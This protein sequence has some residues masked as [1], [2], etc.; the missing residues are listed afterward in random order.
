MF[1][2]FRRYAFLST[3]LGLIL[4]QAAVLY[5]L[6][7]VQG[8]ATAAVSATGSGESSPFRIEIALGEFQVRNFQT[9]GSELLVKFRVCLTVEESNKERLLEAFRKHEQRVREAIGI[10]VRKADEETLGEPSL[11]T[12]KRRLRVAILA[13]MQVDSA[14]LLDVLMPDFTVTR[15]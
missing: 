9:P 11:A 2:I 3:V 14:A 8:S 4:G 13:A 10:A 7:P 6:I 12:L 5:C 1:G 15:R